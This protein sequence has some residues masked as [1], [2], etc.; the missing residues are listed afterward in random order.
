MNVEDLIITMSGSH[1]A[2]KSFYSKEV[3]KKFGLRR[4]SAGKIFRKKA[5]ERNMSVEELSKLAEDDRR[6]DEQLDSYVVREAK[7][8]GVVVDSLLSGWLLKDIAH[9]R[10]CLKAPLNERVKR[11][12]RRDGKKYE[13]A[14]KETNLRERSEKKRFR[15]YY[16]IDIDDLSIY[17]LVID[18]SLTNIKTIKQL[19]FNLIEEYLKTH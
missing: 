12:A 16:G 6:I 9:I 18:T 5:T 8:G 14:L 4:I 19:I 13:D 17:H 2:G 1:G 15:E 3:A 7:K 10:I 11:I